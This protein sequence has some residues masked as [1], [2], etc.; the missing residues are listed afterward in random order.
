MSARPTFLLD[1]NRCTGCLACE[2]ACQIANALPVGR[3]WRRVRTHNPLL[4]GGVRNV[5]LSLACNHC[6]DAPCASQ[7]PADAY[8]RDEATGAWLIDADRCLGCRYCAWVCPYDAPRFDEAAGVM[9]KCTFCSDRQHDG[10]APACAAACP[11]GALDWAVLEEAAW[12]PAPEV[13]GFADV[14]TRPA[15]RVKDLLP[16]RTRPV[17]TVP[18]ATPPWRHLAA[19][20]TPRIALRHE[21]PLV[22]FTALLTALAA[23]TGAVPWGFPAPPPGLLLLVGG[24][25]LGLSA[26][27]LGRRERSWRALLHLRSSELSREIVL[28]GAFVLGGGLVQCL[29]AP[30]AALQWGA[31]L[32]GAGALFTVDRVYAPVR[33]RGGRRLHSAAVLPAAGLIAASL[34]GATV[35]VWGLAVE[36]LVLYLDRKRRRAALDLPWRPVPSILR[37]GCLLATGSVM[38]LAGEAGRPVAA[39]LATLGAWIDRV[40]FYEEMDVPT[41]EILQLE[42]LADEVLARDAG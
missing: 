39:L 33:V 12:T 29:A 32:L 3:D 4:I 26:A 41:P 28:G 30:S 42:R 1:V 31:A 25:S 36:T 9:T 5:H 40:E 18:P 11:T 21:W 22:L 24:A 6:G 19:R 20:I 7:C 8:V 23:W 2:L 10:G 34:I 27:H 13:P 16:G 14:G 17:A 37:C 15:I 38:L 35:V